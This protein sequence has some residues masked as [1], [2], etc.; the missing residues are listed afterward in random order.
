MR[1]SLHGLGQKLDYLHVLNFSICY[2]I[3]H[4]LASVYAFI[5]IKMAFVSKVGSL[6]KQSGN[7]NVSAGLLSS[8]SPFFQAIRSMSSAKLFVGGLAYAT[9]EM[10][11][12]EAF[13]QYGEVIEARVISDRDSGRSR[14]F[15]FV[16]YTSAD[17]AN[18]ALQDMDGKE[19]H[20]RRIRVNFAQE[21]PRPTFG[22]G[23]Y[24]DGSYGGPGGYSGGGGSFGGSGGYSS[25][26]SYRNSGGY[27]DSSSN[28]GGYGGSSQNAG[29]RG[30]LFG[31]SVSGDSPGA[32]MEDDV[33]SNL[34]DDLS[35][36]EGSDDFKDDD[37]ASNTSHKLIFKFFWPTELE[38]KPQ[39]SLALRLDYIP[40]VLFRLSYLTLNLL[41]SLLHT[42]NMIS[43]S[44][45]KLI[46][47]VMIVDSGS[48]AARS[49]MDQTQK[50]EKLVIGSSHCVA[51]GITNCVP[52]R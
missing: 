9:D 13:Q 5:S 37:Y 33:D 12:R 2:L 3:G 26:G 17:A 47:H 18:S 27:G 32:D 35:G 36:N 51:G 21:R 28:Q 44:M 40:L 11:L 49:G 1:R 34:K 7:K 39:R 15:G 16:S 6:L 41:K 24:G 19:L 45:L 4:L 14:G 30:D 52:I 25:G 23:G 31:G 48:A 8:N 42:L 10:G 46:C 22:G 50:L 38:L 20:G 29:G 43:F